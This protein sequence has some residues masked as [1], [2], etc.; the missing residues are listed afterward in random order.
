[1]NEPADGIEPTYS[2]Q[3]AVKR[4]FIAQ[5]QLT[6]PDPEPPEDAINSH[7]F[8]AE[9]IFAAQ[10]LDE[11]EYL[12]NI[13]AVEAMLDDLE[14]RYRDAFLNELPEFE[15]HNPSVEYFAKVFGD[16]LVE[17]LPET[18]AETLEVKLWEDDTAW[19]SHTRS[20]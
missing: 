2:Y 4:D 16:K 1:M 15:G 14:A 11:N 6:V 19:A 9:V 7:Q 5:H 3:L 18:T 8:T 12:V 10:S 13:D 20:L 17:R